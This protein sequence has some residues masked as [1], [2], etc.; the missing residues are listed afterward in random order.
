M[1]LPRGGAVSEERIAELEATLERERA[2]FRE[3]MTTV[4]AAR[5]FDCFHRANVL[6]DERCPCCGGSV[7]VETTHNAVKLRAVT[8]EPW[9][10]RE[11]AL[12]G[13]KE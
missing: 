10:E 7:V 3:M 2:Y 13:R 11:S 5:L 9:E 1:G 8:V 12:N 4:Q 6:K